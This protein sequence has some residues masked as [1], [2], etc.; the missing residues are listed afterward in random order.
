MIKEFYI[1]KKENQ[2][3]NMRVLAN[4]L[5]DL[6]DSRY[7]IRIEKANQRSLP[8][9]SFYWGIVIPFVQDGLKHLGH[10]ITKE[11]THEFL[12]SK[13]NYYEIVNENTGECVSIPKS[14]KR[15]SKIEFGEYIAKI[16]QFAAE[17][18]NIVIPDAN[19]QSQISY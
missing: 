12:K 9:N 3:T 13:F 16:Q 6:P 17:F 2:I 18:L 19:Q 10:D 15:L 8:Q 1:Y 11:E 7:R 14:T 5:N 4:H